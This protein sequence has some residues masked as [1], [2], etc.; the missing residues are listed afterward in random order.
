MTFG[1]MTDDFFHIVSF[2]TANW[3]RVV[4]ELGQFIIHKQLF[5]SST[6]LKISSLYRHDFTARLQQQ[7]L[8]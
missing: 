4:V 2:H 5:V 7:P 3:R 8:P 1:N 6:S